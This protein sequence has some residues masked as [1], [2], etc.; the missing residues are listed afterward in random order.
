MRVFIYVC[1]CMYGCAC[2]C[3]VA[4]PFG[5]LHDIDTFGLEVADTDG[6][7]VL[8]SGYDIFKRPPFAE[9][10]MYRVAFDV[11]ADLFEHRAAMATACMADRDAWFKHDVD[12]AQLDVTGHVNAKPIRVEI[13]F[14]PEVGVHIF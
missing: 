13:M 4:G 8:F 7:P 6:Y 2:H 5:D 11:F 10:E 9:L 12:I 14:P 3:L 1:M